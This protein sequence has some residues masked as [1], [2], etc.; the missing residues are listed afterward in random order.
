MVMPMTR[1]FLKFH[2]Y[3]VVVSALFT[4]IIGLTIW[5][6]TLKTRSNLSNIWNLQ[7]AST[8]SL[9]QQKVASPNNNNLLEE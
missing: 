2:G 9:L 8:Q 6:E 3:L 1:G 5:F 4:M 7:P